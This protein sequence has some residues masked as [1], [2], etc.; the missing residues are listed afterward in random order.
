MFIYI[1]T[2]IYNFFIIHSF[3]NGHLVC[4]H[5]L[6]IVKNAAINIG[7]YISFQTSVFIFFRKIPWSGT[8]RLYGS[9][10]FNFIKSFH[11]VFH[12]SCTNLPSHQQCTGFP[13]LH[14][15]ANT[16]YLLS[17]WY[18][19]FWQVW[20]VVLLW[21]WFAFLWWLVMIIFSCASWPSVCLWKN[22][23]SVSAHFII[24][25]GVFDVEGNNF[26]A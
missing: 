23:S 1:H 12:N 11:T 16:Y 15:L 18:Q 22:V 9:F 13:F 3:T 25:L 19:S 7:V 4:F 2:D 6:A 10:I 20:G 5:I 26:F 14:I 17:F 24:G 8:A 21:F